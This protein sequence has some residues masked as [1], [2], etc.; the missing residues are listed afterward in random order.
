[1]NKQEKEVALKGIKDEKAAIAEIK[2]AYKSA[3]ET[4][5]A[6]ILDLDDGIIARVAAGRDPQSKIY[7]KRYQEA[8]RAEVSGIVDELKGMSEAQITSYL[9]KCYE[10]GF[11]GTAYS[12]HAQGV[13]LTT[14]INQAELAKMITTT[15]GNIKLSERIWQDTPK[16]KTR[17]R[18]EISRGV[19]LGASYEDIA[20]DLK[21][22]LNADARKAYRIARTEGGRVTEA[23]KHAYALKAKEAGADVV[24]EWI[25]AMDSATRPEHVAMDGQIRELEQPFD[26]AGEKGLYPHDFGSP[27][28]DINCRCTVGQRARWA[29]SEAERKQLGEPIEADSF[30]EFRQAYYGRTGDVVGYNEWQKNTGT[31]RV[32]AV[33]PPQVLD[34]PR[35]RPLGMADAL[36]VSNPSGDTLNCQRTV[37]AYE[38][39]RRGYKVGALPWSN[40]IA[41]CTVDGADCFATRDGLRAK[42]RALGTRSELRK[43][44][45]S[46]PI[47]ARYIIGIQWH[48]GATHVFS[49]ERTKTGMV[50]C[51]PQNGAAD[52]ERYFNQGG[53]LGYARIDDKLLNGY[54]E[55][56]KILSTKKG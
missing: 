36:K 42:M 10:S 12:F 31:T 50:F 44:T 3:L 52:V 53:L 14:P 9:G 55:W 1:L 41:T 27:E 37:V 35:G 4:L 38:L 46:D 54:T 33:T 22:R 25:A 40:A 49:A 28:M 45:R 13:P 24:K 29:L 17:I 26:G 5:D 43:A 16:L 23:S 56:D 32:K 2:K 48:D 21:L 6:K 11:V 20:R 47:G 8:L 30:G 15:N 39:N 34:V 18:Q 7:Q 51:D 19:A